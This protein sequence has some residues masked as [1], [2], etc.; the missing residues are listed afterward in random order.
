MEWPALALLG[1]V[2]MLSIAILCYVFC[3]AAT[4]FISYYFIFCLFKLYFMVY[5]LNF[6]FAK[7]TLVQDVIFVFAILIGCYCLEYLSILDYYLFYLLMHY[8]LA[9]IRI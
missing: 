3:S 4:L 5:S 7:I 8:P 2:P 1:V 9:S 6:T